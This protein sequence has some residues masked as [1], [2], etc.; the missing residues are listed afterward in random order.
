MKRR[1][2][3]TILSATA[4]VVAVFGSTP[5]GEAAVRTIV[6]QNSVGTA[7]LRT[8][9]VT[10]AKVKPGSLTA[11]AFKAG[12]LPAGPKGD[13]GPAG[14]QG[15]QGPKGD[16]GAAGVSGYQNVQG[17]V[18]S[19]A[20]GA[21]NISTATCPAGKRSLGGGVAGG[22]PMAIELSSPVGGSGWDV[23]VKNLGASTE[24]FAAVAVCATIGG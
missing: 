10:G 3:P 11:A 21:S 24:T 18:V 15:A 17:T 19:V 13:Q 6:P 20:P 22:F 5:L 1:H 23:E 9:A 4:L 2:L 7:Q 12:Q 16:T 8:G 14:P